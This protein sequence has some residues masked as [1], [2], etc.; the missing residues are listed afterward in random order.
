MIILLFNRSDNT[1]KVGGY[2][3]EESQ[4]YATIYTIYYLFY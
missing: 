3:L 2:Y 4:R 1:T